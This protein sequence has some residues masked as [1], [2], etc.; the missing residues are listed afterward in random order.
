MK[1][2]L[3]ILL[4]FAA[5]VVGMAG[6]ALLVAT[7]PEVVAE[8][9][10]PSVPLVRVVSAE[11]ERLVHRVDT[12][13]TV[14]PRTESELVPEVSG[15]VE[16]IAGSFASGGFFSKGDPL[17]RIEP[18][19]YEV[20]LRRARASVA[21][22]DSELA[23]ASREANRQRTLA[24][25]KVASDSRLDDAVNAEKVAA[26]A[27]DEAQAALVQAERDL[28]R[29]TIV[30]P[31][32]G[33]VRDESVDVGQ[34]V[35]R[36]ARIGTIYSVDVAEVRLPV[37]DS[38][39]A[40]LDLPLLYDG[41]DDAT[42]EAKVLLHADF[43]GR[44]HTW[45][46]RVVRT[47]GEI[48]P[49]TRMVHVVAQVEAPYARSEAGRPPLKA[50]LFVDAEILGR[51]DE[52]VVLLPRAALREGDRV[53]V[54]DDETRLRWRPVEVL[55]A[56]RDT[57]VIS[58]GLERGERVC[59]SALEAAVDGMPVR[60]RDAAGTAHADADADDRAS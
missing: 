56:D 51:A 26:A 49:R 12:H 1:L 22:S 38:Q 44:R 6:A 42:H 55:R 58:G 53:W 34:F 11:P 4:P 46:G 18:G 14:E 2:P 59:I 24:D 5:V 40:F 16:W 39:L 35:N 52:D 31:F 21:R 43:A 29:T 36:G 54:V 7:G 50:G 60:V 17:L 13:G 27:L 20:A 8:P 15:R 33:R 10:P 19:D 3:R 48:D 9:P 45:E 37:P 47:E 28:A 30:A 57:V 32:D 41:G 25:Q 23:R